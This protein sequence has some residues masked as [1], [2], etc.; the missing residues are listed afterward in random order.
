MEVV[1]SGL[2]LSDGDAV[3]R[4][5]KRN[6]R[7]LGFLPRKALDDYLEKGTVLGARGDSGVLAGYLLYAANPFRFRVVHLCVSDDFREQRIARRLVDELKKTAT[8][9]KGIGLHCRRDYSAHG[10]WNALGFVPLNEKP[11]RAGTGHTL[12]FWYLDLAPS[13]RL[14]LFRAD[15]S[16]ETVDVVVDS[17]ILFD[18]HEPE[19]D[20]TKPSKSLLSDFLADAVHSFLTDEIYLE[21][22]RNNDPERREVPSLR[23]RRGSPVAVGLQVVSPTDLI[24]R[25]HELLER[26]SYVP[27]RVAGVALASLERMRSVFSEDGLGLTLQSPLRIPG[28]TFQKIFEHGFSRRS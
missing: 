4:L 19:N 11:S 5:M 9:Q 15:T 20:K 3:D 2:T 16:E 28:K 26:Q 25:H 13:E 22:D 23:G 10:M 14:G 21:I 8:T 7:T 6:S 18:F 24:I 12:T 1:I 17:Q 27:D